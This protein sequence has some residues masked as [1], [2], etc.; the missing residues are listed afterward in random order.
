MGIDYVQLTAPVTAAV[1][2]LLSVVE[3][4]TQLDGTTRWRSLLRPWTPSRR[5]PVWENRAQHH[6][7]EYW[8]CR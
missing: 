1:V 2:F 8:Q 5:L 6:A 4:D 3:G 7:S